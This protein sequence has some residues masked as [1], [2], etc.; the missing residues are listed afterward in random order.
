MKLA[1]LIL[2][3][4][5]NNGKALIQE[6]K[7]L[8]R[9]LCFDFGGFTKLHGVGGWVDPDDS[10]PTTAIKR[11]LVVVYH[12]AMERAAVPKL[13]STAAWIGRLARQ[14]CVMIVTPGG[15][16]EMVPM[17]HVPENYQP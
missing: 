10:N 11:E 8:Q 13:R 1:Q 17:H 9:A 14:K 4:Q 3:E 2:P 12:I 5:D 16:V 6:H 15:D 7:D